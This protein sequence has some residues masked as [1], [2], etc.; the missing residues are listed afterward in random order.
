MSFITLYKNQ[1][2]F[3]EIDQFMRSK[4]FVPHH[5]YTS[6]NWIIA[7]TIL[8]GDFR[9]PLNQILEADVVYMRDMIHPDGV[10]D[11]TLRRTAYLAEVVYDS[12]D[13]SIRCIL[14]LIRRGRMPEGSH[15]AYAQGYGE[16]REA[17]RRRAGT[18]R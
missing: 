13:L 2:S 6:K 11:E 8:G 1:P 18:P 10:D 4:G 15:G 3:G 17:R 16:R 9:R 7:P 5:I 12:L 14:E